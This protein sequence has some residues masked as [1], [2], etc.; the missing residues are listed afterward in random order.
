MET[1]TR[2]EKMLFFAAFVGVLLCVFGT[3]VSAAGMH[4]WF[5]T[6]SSIDRFE[7]FPFLPHVHIEAL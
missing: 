5:L 4:D 6:Y 7:M 1:V 3:F 2:S